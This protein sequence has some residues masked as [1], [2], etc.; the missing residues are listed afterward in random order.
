[1]GF[2]DDCTSMLFRQGPDGQRVFPRF[3]LQARDLPRIS[4]GEVMQRR[5][6]A[7]RRM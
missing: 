6:K 4:R 5:A 7:T 3:D 2:F 1:V